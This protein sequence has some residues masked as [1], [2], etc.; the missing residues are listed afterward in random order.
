MKALIVIDMLNDFV[1]GVIANKGPADRITPHIKRLIDHARGRP[2]WVVVYANDA[3]RWDDPELKI[4][5]PHAMAGTHGAAVIDELKPI[6]AEREIISNKRFYGAFDETGLGEDLDRLGV[7]EVIV[8]GQHTHCCCR[9]TSYAAYM[10]GYKITV[11]ADAVCVF[12]NM[13]NE[14]AIDYLKIHYQANVTTTDAL[15]A[16]NH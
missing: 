6:G 16:S 12:E 9:H 15:I 13:D 4:W 3:H 14:A 10:R 11:P 5:G 7:E 8:T 1:D 2:D